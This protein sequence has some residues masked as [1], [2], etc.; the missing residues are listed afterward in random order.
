MNACESAVL[1]VF[2]EGRYVYD[3]CVV[4]FGVQ[5]LCPCV[6]HSVGRSL[7]TSTHR[8]KNPTTPLAK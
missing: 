8:L 3:C 7:L 6:G 1:K 2:K 4:L 5:N